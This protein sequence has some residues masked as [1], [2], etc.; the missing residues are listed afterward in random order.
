ML[1]G[2]VDI[3][4]PRRPDHGVHRPLRGSPS[5]LS[6]LPGTG[7]PDMEVREGLALRRQDIHGSNAVMRVDCYLDR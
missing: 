3:E 2:R 5:V 6:T 4:A 7:G 1:K